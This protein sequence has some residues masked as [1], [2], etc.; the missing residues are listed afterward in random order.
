MNN[1]PNREETDPGST[2]A[3]LS[4]SNTEERTEQRNKS[5][6]K[7]LDRQIAYV[8]AVQFGVDNPDDFLR[9]WKSKAEW[10]EKEFG[11]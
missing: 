8:W 11:W 6:D 5:Y 10:H 4:K 3:K 7:V 2:G 9:S 1:V